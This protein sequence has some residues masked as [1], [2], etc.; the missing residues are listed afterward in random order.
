MV[1]NNALQKNSAQNSITL[2]TFI[3]VEH[4][5]KIIKLSYGHTKRKLGLIKKEAKVSGHRIRLDVFLEH[6]HL[7]NSFFYIKEEDFIGL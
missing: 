1:L 2:P 6:K 5:Q 4:V 3:T 7:V